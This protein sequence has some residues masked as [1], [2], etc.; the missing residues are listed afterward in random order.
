[1]MEFDWKRFLTYQLG[2]FSVTREIP[3]GYKNVTIAK[4]DP[5]YMCNG[6]KQENC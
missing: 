3:Q 2:L 1:M 4:L 5:N 6:L